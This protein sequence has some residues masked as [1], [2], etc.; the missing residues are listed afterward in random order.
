MAYTTTTN[1]GLKKGSGGSGQTIEQQR[2]YDN[3]NAD[4]IDATMKSISNAANA[5]QS[6]ADTAQATANTAQGEVDALETLVSTILNQTDPTKKYKIVGC[7]L[8]NNGSGVW[9]Q[10]GGAHT[11]LNVLS[12]S[13]GTTY[14]RVNYNFTAKNVVSF[15]ACPDDTFIKGGYQFG[16]DVGLSFTNI[17]IT[18]EHTLGGFIYYSGGAWNVN[19]NSGGL[20]GTPTFD[21]GILTIPHNTISGVIATVNCM[22][23]KYVAAIEEVGATAT[24]VKFFDYAGN[25]VTTPTTDM[26]VF[27]T[28]STSGETL[29]NPTTLNITGANIWC[30]GIFEIE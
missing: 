5:A 19:G 23:G 26:K 8:Q 15:V 18:K 11:S 7:V 10:V 27:M 4:T 29:V 22:G 1:Y 21:A 16:S 17:N 30:Y 2:V 14:V 28:R 24:K 20:T 25:L 6:D 13:T 3:E 9:Q 12:I